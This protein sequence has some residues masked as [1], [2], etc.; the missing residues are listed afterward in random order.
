MVEEKKDEIKKLLEE[1]LSR[2][3]EVERMVRSIKRYILF[4]QIRS[5]IW[6]LAIIVSLV[7]AY[8]YLPPFIKQIYQ[9]YQN[10]WQLL[11]R[12]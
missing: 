3:K 1:N 9:N 8:L 2:T 6:W 7:A 4:S 11:L 10:I 5:I 12:Q